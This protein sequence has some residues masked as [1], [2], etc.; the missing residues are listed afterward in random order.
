MVQKVHLYSGGSLFPA[1]RNPDFPWFRRSGFHQ[2]S[3]NVHPGRN[4]LHQQQCAHADRRCAD[5]YLCRI[6]H[7]TKGNHR[8]SGIFRWRNIQKQKDVH[9]YDQVDR[10][11]LFDRDPDQFHFERTRHYHYVNHIRGNQLNRFPLS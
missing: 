4:G 7:Q 10:S 5:L 6:Y 1:D 2:A 11:N 3:G 9:C 8:R